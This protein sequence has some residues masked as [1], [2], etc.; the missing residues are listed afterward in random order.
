[1]KKL[2]LALVLF[3]GFCAVNFVKADPIFVLDD[4]NEFYNFMMNNSAYP[5][6]FTLTGKLENSSAVGV[7]TS[8]EY[9]HSLGYEFEDRT[10][11]DHIKCWFQNK[12]FVTFDLKLDDYVNDYLK[13]TKEQM[14]EKAKDFTGGTFML[15]MTEGQIYVG[16]CSTELSGYYTFLQINNAHHSASSLDGKITFTI[17][18]KNL[19]ISIRIQNVKP[20]FDRPEILAMTPADVAKNYPNVYWMYDFSCYK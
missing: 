8:E 15:S 1:M 11:W 7:Q 3:L 4:S 14:Q 13:L 19:T 9:I 16:N 12:Y 6:D 18:I 17:D 20:Y 2:I 10:G 5:N